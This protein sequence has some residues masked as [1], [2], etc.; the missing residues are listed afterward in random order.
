MWVRELF[1]RVIPSVLRDHPERVKALGGTVFFAIS[2][3]RGGAW[4]IDPTAPVPR[5]SDHADG[6]IACTV[7]ARDD[8]FQAMLDDPKAAVALF[9]QGK[10]RVTGDVQI[11][12]RFHLLLG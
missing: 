1:E 8:D 11:M 3:E 2:G 9:Q 10:I 5:V 12:A 7:H 6:V 4:F